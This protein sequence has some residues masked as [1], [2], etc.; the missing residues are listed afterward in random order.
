ML[1][2]QFY[3][4]CGVLGAVARRLVALAY[5]QSQC[6]GTDSATVVRCLIGK[7]RNV[8]SCALLRMAML[9]RINCY[10]TGDKAYH[11]NMVAFRQNVW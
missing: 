5:G 1:C 7:L 9:L 6:A 2:R 3:E 11:F 10:S 4:K 8:I